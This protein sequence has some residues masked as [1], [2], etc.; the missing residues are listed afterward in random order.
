MNLAIAFFLWYYNLLTLDHSIINALQQEY[1]KTNNPD[2]LAYT[3]YLTRNFKEAYLMLPKTS[4]CIAS[5]IKNYGLPP[6]LP[7]KCSKE[8]PLLY[9]TYKVITFGDTLPKNQN[10]PQPLKELLSLHL[11]AITGNINTLKSKIL[12]LSSNNF[13]YPK[14]LA[15]FNHLYVNSTKDIMNASL[16]KV[17]KQLLIARYYIN[18]GKYKEAHRV[19]KKII[20]EG[21]VTNRINV[22]KEFAK[23]AYKISK[24]DECVLGYSFLYNYNSLP[25]YAYKVAICYN[26]MGLNHAAN[27][28][29]IKGQKLTK[30]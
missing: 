19:L 14:V 8:Y 15:Y 3:L 6:T 24:W 17:A 10:I 22:V 30:D 23:I 9:L 18:E 4:E 21:K 20:E 1:L 28:W 13:P 7:K 12:K 11:L 25:K 5:F 27:I 29:I 26:R 2:I 16:P